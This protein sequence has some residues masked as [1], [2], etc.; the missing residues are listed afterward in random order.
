MTAAVDVLLVARSALSARRRCP[1]GVRL[2]VVTADVR[3]RR[4]GRLVRGVPLDR[5]ASRDDVAKATTMFPRADGRAGASSGGQYHFAI[6]AALQVADGAGVAKRSGSVD[7]LVLALVESV[8]VRHVQP[9]RRP[10]RY[11]LADDVGRSAWTGLSGTS[12]QACA[13]IF[14]PFMHGRPSSVCSATMTQRRVSHVDD[15]RLR[16]RFAVRLLP[17]ASDLAAARGRP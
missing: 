14:L 10:C 16:T 7:G 8:V 11:C 3:R 6:E 9:R 12:S 2:R 1:G 17:T 4:L 13:C 15:G 5:T